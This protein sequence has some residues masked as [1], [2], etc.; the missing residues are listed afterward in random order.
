MIFA[1]SSKHLYNISGKATSRWFELDNENLKHALPTDSSVER[2]LSI[3]NMT[4]VRAFTT[5]TAVLNATEFAFEIETATH[6][7]SF[8]CHDSSIRDAW[9]QALSA[10][11]EKFIVDNSS[12]KAR[13]VEI[14]DLTVEKVLEF[15][16]QFKE[17]CRI[18]GTIIMDDHR[19]EVGDLGIN[20]E[21]VKE[22][23][24]LLHEKLLVAGLSSK[25]LLIMHEYLM[26]PTSSETVWDNI[27]GGI[28]K[29]R[30]NCRKE[31]SDD[32]QDSFDFDF[33]SERSD[34]YSMDIHPSGTNGYGRKQQESGYAEVDSLAT[35]TMN[36]ERENKE[37]KG[38]IRQLEDEYISNLKSKKKLLSKEEAD[39]TK[40]SLKMAERLKAYEEQA[41]S[42]VK[43]MNRLQDR[44]RDL[45]EEMEFL[46]RRDAFLATTGSTASSNAFQSPTSPAFSNVNP[47]R[48]K[49]I[50]A[51]R[52]LTPL[53]TLPSENGTTDQANCSNGNT[54]VV[55]LANSVKVS[56]ELNVSVTETLTPISVPANEVSSAPNAIAL[57]LPAIATD[58]F[59]KYRKMLKML[60]SAAVQQKMTMDGISAAEIESFLSEGSK[61]TSEQSTVPTATP[62]QADDKLEKY[63]KMLKLLPEHAVRQKMSLEGYTAQ[64]I[65]SF[66]Q[67]TVQSPAPPASGGEGPFSPKYEKFMKMLKLLPEHAVRQKMTMEGISVEEIEQVLSASKGIGSATSVSKPTDGGINQ[68]DAPDDFTTPPDGMEPKVLAVKPSVK[69]KG[70]YWSKL[71]SAEVKN[72]VFHKLHD[73]PIPS[74]YLQE[75]DKLFAA[76]ASKV[77]GRRT[78]GEQVK[79]KAAEDA[80]EEK[81]K[82]NKLISVVDSNRIQNI[83]IVMGKLR[84]GPEDVM[85]LVIDLDPDVMTPDITTSIISILPLAEEA[86]AIRLH[87]DPSKLDKASRLVYHL[88]RIP[89]LVTRVECHEVT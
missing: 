14:G 39:E 77:V 66:V 85:R 47:L 29:I 35:I 21:D 61:P 65:D 25:L 8:G 51:K 67:G 75:I 4:D 74:N 31:D 48:R 55:S 18:Y 56:S 28:R 64:Q 1:K 52:S 68:Q 37:L 13:I 82:S 71:K 44:V 63:R 19:Y 45:E 73:F 12:Y 5:S 49:S 87:T 54:I 22:V 70:L 58:K 11:R 62:V 84:L 72:T 3:A 27:Y 60:P 79:N 83:L 24:S 46:K 2:F 40:K 9:L 33:G 15:A 26:I 20:V 86:N 17:Q 50:E 7:Y 80:S 41:I 34:G 42:D 16:Q 30:T 10:N 36:L 57:T 53:L 43:E 76:T 88:C 89:R 59:E 78:D 69:L 81:D 38:R 6:I 23:F 32:S